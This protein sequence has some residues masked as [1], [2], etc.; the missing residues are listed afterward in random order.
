MNGS[1]HSPRHNKVLAMTQKPHVR[2][3]DFVVVL[4]SL[5]ILHLLLS[6]VLWM[7][8]GA[9]KEDPV[10][11]AIVPILSVA[12]Y[13]TKFGLMVLFLKK[14]PFRVDKYEAPIAFKKIWALAFS[15]LLLIK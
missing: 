9:E 2:F 4:F 8:F 3:I 12:L 5:D 10:V 14:V 15:W 13:W 1:G 6:I 7:V 11:N